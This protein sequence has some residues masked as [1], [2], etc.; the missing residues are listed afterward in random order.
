MK[1]INTAI[2]RITFCALGFVLLST[3]TAKAQI[4]STIAGTGTSGHT[5]D[6]SAAVAATLNYPSGVAFDGS[7]NMYIA[8]FS[9]NYI[10]KVNTSGVITTFA[11]TGSAGSTGD[12]SAATSATLNNPSGIAVDGSGNLYIAEATGN[13]IR[14]ITASTGVIST[15]AGTGTGSSTGDGSA[16]TSATLNFPTDLAFDGSGNLYISENGGNRIRKITTSTGVISTIAGTGTASSTGDGS[17]ATSA[18]LNNPAGIVFD[19]SGNLYIAENAGHKIR[20]ITASTGVISTIAGT[21]TASST[22]DGGAATSATVKY[23][24]GLAIDASSNLYFSEENGYR[25]R[26]INTS[27]NVAA[28]AGTGT[29]G[30][31]G[32]GSAAPSATFKTPYGIAFNSGNLFI[33]D[34]NSYVIRKVCNAPSPTVSSTISY[35]QG[36]TAV[37]LTATG[38]NLLWYT[39]ATGGIGSTIAPTPSTSTVGTTVYYVTQTPTTFGCESPRIS[40]SVVINTTPTAPT[41]VT[42]VTYCSGVTASALTATK[43]TTT[44]T[45]YWYTVATGGTGTK[46]APTPSTASAGTTPY[47]VSEIST[48]GCEGPRANINV[49][50]NATPTTPTVTT[51]VTYCSGVTASA[52]TATLVNPTDTLR[53]YT[54]A[55][56]G[57]GSTT[58]PVPST[59]SAGT[60]SYYVSEKSTLGCEGARSAIS[61]VVNATPAAPTV[62][63]TLNYCQGVTA[64][65]L[66]ATKITGTDTLYWYTVATGGIGSTIAPTPSTATVGTVSYY[67]SEKSTLGCEGPRATISVNTK[68]IPA[69]PTVI[70]PVNYCQGATAVALTAT[71][72]A[73]SDTLYWYNSAIGGSGTVTA[74]TPSTATLGSTNYYVSERSSFSCEG[75]RAPITVNINAIPAAPTTTATVNYCIGATAT[76]LT[77]T[78]VTATDTLYWYT[79]ATGG[80]GS[81][82]APTPSTATVGTTSY[83]VS[84]R[85]VFGCEGSRAAITVNI[86]PLATA[87]T[88]VSPIAYCQGKSA[89]ALTATKIASSDTLYWYTVATGGTGTT[90]APTPS[91]IT[92]GATS[93]YV[94]SKSSFGCEGSRSTITVNINPLATAPTVTSPVVYCQGVTASPL[95]ATTASPSDTLYWYTVAT[96]GTGTTT[97]PTPST[98]SVGTTNYYVS[99]RSSFGC[100][101]SRSLIAVNI[102]AAPAAPTVTTPVNYC[103]GATASALTATGTNVLWYSAATGGTGS[104]TAPTPTTATAGSISYYVTQT[105]V[106][107]GCESPRAAIVVVSNALPIAPVVTSPINLCQGVTASALTATK[108]ST[109]DTLYWYS[110]PTGGTGST[111][112]PVP[113]TA[114]VRYDSFYVSLK[115]IF[116]CEGPRSV[117]TDT[118]RALPA[119]PTV[120]TPVTYCQ[121]VT[122][123]ALT[124]VSGSNLKWYT[125]AT[126]GTST[127]TVTP[128]TA[129]AGSTKY[130]VSQS[131]ASSLGG[132][133]S[134]R[135]SIA[136]VV[137]PAPSAPTITTPVNLCVG[138]S[139]SALTATLATSTDTLYWYTVATGG[140]GTTTAPT[141]STTS[142][143]TT[144]YYVGERTTLGCNGSRATINVIVNALPAAPTVTT[145]INLCVGGSGTTLTA[146]GSNLLWYTVA[147]AGTGTSTAPSITTGTAS[148]TIYYVSQSLAAASGGCEGPR[149]ALTVNVNALPAAPTV[150]SPLNLCIGVPATTTTLTATGTNLLWYAASSGGTGTTAAPIPSTAT[151][152]STNYYVSQTS[153]AS[154]G[155]CESPRATIVATVN[156]L[157]LVSISSLSPSGFVFCP[158]KTI[159]LKANAPTAVSYQWSAFGSPYA[160]ATH[161]TFTVGLSGLSGRRGVVVTDVYGCIGRD[162]VYVQKDT[163][164]KPVLD[165]TILTICQGSASL[166]NCHPS[167]TTYTFQWFNGT[168]DLGVSPTTSTLSV[169]DTGTYSVVVTN[170]FGCITTTNTA[171]VNY[172]PLI[173]KPIVIHHDP[174]LSVSTS[175]FYYQWYLN[176]TLIAGAVNKTYTA[177]YTGKYYVVVTDANGCTATSDTTV[178]VGLG[179]NDPAQSSSVKVYPNPSQGKVIIESPVNVAI[180]VT[181]MTGRVLL[182][183]NHVKEID[184]SDFADGMYFFRISDDNGALLK[185]EKINKITAQ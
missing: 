125:V 117:I 102:T 113:N 97:A 37:P 149:T 70:T 91:T 66:T 154:T 141:P 176:G 35:C 101:G 45:L 49:V 139:A 173:A 65:A 90:T 54:V 184:L 24:R 167:F 46:T 135:D 185:L 75:S 13:R 44:D 152:G 7:G 159:I 41:I 56:G 168:V 137:N 115:T 147:T 60:T 133:E 10:R 107:G 165:P 47:Y 30:Y 58:A 83:Y 18:T 178:V 38:T 14:K 136:V 175:Y 92:V 96:G 171:K 40:I 95:T 9:G 22:G 80:T 62:T 128:S 64:S 76:V 162:S 39:S 53:W 85:S 123:S 169:T 59:A 119:K 43:V 32:D 140:T 145:P 181:D 170:N 79:V 179:I 88:V 100:E 94:S 26:V 4:I 130:Y 6:G 177:L 27:G 172:Y 48:L 17:A 5:G 51:P 73:A 2:R 182:Q 126:G 103:V 160:G 151:L 132:C 1:K 21:G 157:P 3:I 174:T 114:T 16:A 156:P 78:P 86:N 50:V 166:L 72:G 121:G 143:G 161:D 129:T 150:T 138:G 112:A 8:E 84:E 155:S 183:K 23:P 146:T 116:G 127:A 122:A 31:S 11:G 153:G 104:T 89:S 34:L 93:Y 61:V 105:P 108:V 111:T 120:T 20:K 99:S 109:T 25:I 163:T 82:T 57:T 52:L 28:F 68:A 15:I 158:G 36:V 142:A 67:V 33:A 87:P 81:T 74:P 42:P 63:T 124:V 164:P 12:G 69:A 110:L 131:L 180:I 118:V 134:V 55:T 19:A 77:A 148:S 29:Y 98:T 106:L 144:P 71:K